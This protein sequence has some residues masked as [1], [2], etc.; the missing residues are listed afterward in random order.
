MSG[1]IPTYVSNKRGGKGDISKLELGDIVKFRNK[2]MK[3][4]YSYAEVVTSPKPRNGLR[5]YSGKS[6]EFISKADAIR[7]S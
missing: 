1:R 5:T 6:F 7:L 2:K 3:D 4:N